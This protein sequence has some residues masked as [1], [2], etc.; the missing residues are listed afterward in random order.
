MEPTSDSSIKTSFRSQNFVRLL[1]LPFNENPESHFLKSVLVS[2]TSPPSKTKR[3]SLNTHFK[4]NPSFLIPP[5]VTRNRYTVV[6]STPMYIC[7]RPTSNVSTSSTKILGPVSSKPV[8]SV[9]YRPVLLY[10]PLLIVTCSTN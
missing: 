1:K 9:S 3:T 10:P 7:S 4:L 5:Y 2:N 8:T 6:P